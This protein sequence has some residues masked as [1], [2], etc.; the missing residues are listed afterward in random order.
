MSDVHHA[1][2][3]AWNYANDRGLPLHGFA[4]CYGT[5]PLLAQFR[6]GGCGGV[7]KSINTVS[8]LFRLD[9]IL[10]F[11]DFARIFSDH[12]GQE[13]S[14]GEFFARLGRG[15]INCQ[16][17]A[18]RDALQEYLKGLFP[19]LRIGRDFFEEL[20][21]HRV[22]IPETLRQLAKARYWKEL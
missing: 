3:W 12:L 7:L 22:R 6:K 4:T 11:E 8:G 10:R 9:Q 17:D 13:L 14:I 15:T 19:E 2:V 5:I 18:F 21:Y 16:G 20:P 1:L